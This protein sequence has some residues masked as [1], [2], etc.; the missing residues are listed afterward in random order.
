MTTFKNRHTST[1]P[2]ALIAVPSLGRPVPLEWAVAF[3]ALHFPINYNSNHSFIFG[4]PVDEARNAFAKQAIDTNT[5]YIFFLGDDVEPPPHTLKQLI[6]RMENNSQ[7][8][9]VGGVYCSKTE[10]S[11]PLVFKENGKG[12]YWDWKAG[13]FFQVSGLGMDCT[14]VRTEVFKQLEEP[15][16][17]TVDTDQFEDGVNKADMWTE[18]LYFCNK[19]IEETDFDIYV[20]T[21][22]IC[23]HWDVY[24]GKAY[25][26]PSGSLPTRSP[27]MDKEKLK[28]IDV[29]CG[30]VRI[31]EQEQYKD[32]DILRVDLDE[33]WEPDYRADISK[34]P[35]DTNQFDLVYSSHTLE[36]FPRNK[37]C[38]V[39][40][41]WVRVLKPGGKLHLIVPNI[42]WAIDNWDEE[43][44][45]INVYNVLFGG[46]ST[47]FDFHMNGITP[48]MLKEYCKQEKLDIETLNESVN[49]TY[50]MFL[51]A[52]KN[53]P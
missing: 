8:G 49:G 26:L 24:E 27:I 12:S 46:Q 36:H 34:L 44:E 35:F 28:G 17:K 22:V 2:G 15:W 45:I 39:L 51:E 33:Q 9:I 4:H 42:E 18:D 41:E 52:I 29:G 32:Y 21:A 53:E 3:K 10:P 50:N 31:S 37:T 40:D 1:G 30:P 43:S 38:E 14:L 13:E 19:V 6:Y 23:R 47:E 11:S 5:K 20:D 48:F 7:I 25:S 16:F